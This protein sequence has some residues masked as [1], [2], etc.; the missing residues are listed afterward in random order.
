MKSP[1]ENARVCHLEG[2]LS[3]AETY[4]RET[5]QWQ[6]D[7]VEALQGLG[8]LAYQRGQIQEAMAH[9]ARGVAIRPE[10]ADFH[11]NLAEVLRI[12][13]RTDEAIEHARKG[14]ALDP[15]LPDAWNTTGLLAHDQR[16]FADAEAA[17]REAIRLRPE[18][19]SAHN[20]LGNTL[21]AL[22]RLNDATE[23][24][25][26]AIRLEPRSAAALTNL[27]RVLI[28]SDDPELLDQAEDLCRRALAVAPEMSQAT[29]TLGNVFRLQG[30]PD[31][32]MACYERALRLDQSSAMPCLNIGKLFQQFAK[33]DDA[34]RWFDKA[35]ALNPSPTQL[36]CSWGS[37]WAAREQFDESAN[38]Y[39]MALAHDAGSAESHF[40]LGTALRE[41]GKLDAAETSFQ[42]AI[43]I[44][45][46][47]PAPWAALAQLYGERGEL[48]RSCQTARHALALRPNQVNAYVQLALNLK[49]RLS[50]AEIEAMEGLLRQRY[51][52]D[53]IRAQLLF[54]LAGIHDE[55]GD[56]ALAAAK[57]EAANAI[58]AQARARR[59]QRYDP[60]EYTRFVD[61]IIATFTP[62]LFARARD[63]GEPDPRPVFVVGLPRSGTT[64][65]EQ[66]IA[67]HPLAHGMG[68]LDELRRVFNALPELVGRPFTGP[69]DALRD[70]DPS[71]S[72]AAARR[73]LDR[74]DS[75]SPS[76]AVRVV[77][78]MLDN[79]DLLGLIA[80]LWPG[81]R[82]IVCRRDLRDVAVSCWQTGFASILWANDHDHIA[83]RFADYQR[84]M[85]HWKRTKPL[86]WLDVSYEEVV[87]DVR[88][89]CRRIIDF[90]GLEWDPVCLQFHSNKRPVRTASQS[91]VRQPTHPRSVGRWRNYQQWLGPL[92]QALQRHGVELGEDA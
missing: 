1:L 82:V 74:L 8:V 58:Q 41:Q 90:L 12:M 39:R 65:V 92:F 78:K 89:Q 45:P 88:V 6:P 57:L 75:L 15:T 51:L 14:L 85:D 62:D 36:Y 72:K 37:L 25:R 47:R 55:L 81:A 33:Y 52:T 23:S 32:A 17:F 19:W 66:M 68:E 18:H 29:N 46:T 16:R 24:F 71:L 21:E 35:Q 73:Y 83:R 20:N 56:Y 4:Y 53:D 7:A 91:Q 50:G 64:L 43:A 54:G 10:A 48:E 87:G 5:L 69:F 77:D 2:R 27:A 84:V 38:C 59:G 61:R 26:T 11:S 70:L 49:G 44:D 3:E 86:R 76:S 22:G 79:A 67:T 13:R 42:R 31:E 34:A 60:A 40:G 30:R 63:W 80:V 28:D 9:F